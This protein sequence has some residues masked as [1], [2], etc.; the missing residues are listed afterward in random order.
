MQRVIKLTESELKKI[1]KQVIK[2]EADA[3]GIKDCLAPLQ[4]LGLQECFDKSFGEM[5]DILGSNVVSQVTKFYQCASL[6][7]DRGVVQAAVKEVVTCLRNKG[8]YVNIDIKPKVEMDKDSWP[9]G[10]SK[11]G[12]AIQKGKE[13][14][15]KM[16]KPGI[17]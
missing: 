4:K 13:M 12:D 16:G 3:N 6:K 8:M 9:Q 5:N 14:L 15:N 11:V 2:E 17:Q 10:S 1:I 7:K